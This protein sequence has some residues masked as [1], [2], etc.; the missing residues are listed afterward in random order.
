MAYYQKYTCPFCK[1]SQVGD[2]RAHQCDEKQLNQIEMTLR[3]PTR[4][5]QFYN[6][7]AKFLA[8]F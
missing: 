7:W 4:M 6:D 1:E 5:S 3:S 2:P 8:K